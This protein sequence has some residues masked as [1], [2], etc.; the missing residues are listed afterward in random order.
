MSLREELNE[1]MKD[2][3]RAQ[4]R[5]RLCTIRLIQAAIKDRDLAARAQGQ[6]QVADDVVQEILGKMVRQREDSIKTYESAG[7][8]DLVEQET[9]E[10]EI[11]SGFMVPQMDDAEIEQAVSAAVAEIEANSLRDMGRTMA[12]LKAEYAGRMDFSKA[13]TAVKQHLS[14]SAADRQLA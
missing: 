2:A 8:I 5:R 6:E 11:I 14:G 9:A 10:V 3:M 1:A 13:C 4:N 7:R 12:Y